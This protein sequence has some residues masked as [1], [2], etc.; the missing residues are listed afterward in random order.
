MAGSSGPGPV[1]DPL[2][3]LLDDALVIVPDLLFEAATQ[4]RRAMS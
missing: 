3:E 4:D 2:K 1:A